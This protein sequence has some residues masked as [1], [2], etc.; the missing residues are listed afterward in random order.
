MSRLDDQI[1]HVATTMLFIPR[2]LVAAGAIVA[3]VYESAQLGGSCR[4]NGGIK[5]PTHQSRPLMF[6]NLRQPALTSSHHVRD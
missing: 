3:S 1:S 6:T 5:Y 2:I 4:F